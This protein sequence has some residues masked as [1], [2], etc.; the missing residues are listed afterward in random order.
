MSASDLRSQ[1]ETVRA[2]HVCGSGVVSSTMDRGVGLR[3]HECARCGFAYVSPRPT[4]EAM[5]R[6]YEQEYGNEDLDQRWR[7]S[8][9]FD[10]PGADVRRVERLIG[11]RG[12]RGATVLDVGCGPGMLLEALRRRGARQLFGI[13]PGAEAV[14][15]ARGR[16][17]QATI[18]RGTFEDAGGALGQR[19]F[20]LICGCDLIEHLYDPRAFVQ[21]ARERLTP[22]GLLY[23]KTPNWHAVGRYGRSW[24]GLWRD[25]E[26]IFYFSRSTLAALLAQEG[27]ATVAV[28]YE[29]YRAGLGGTS[30]LP[31]LPRGQRVLRL[32]RA[33][34]RPVP[35]VNRLTY[36]TL[37][38][39][40]SWRNRGDRREGTAHALIVAAR[41][42]DTGSATSTRGTAWGPS[43]E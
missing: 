18:I 5:L 4:Q 25:F 26:H 16:L 36:R 9:A 17:P 20:D 10:V 30:R 19:T 27:L 34:V 2:C 40:R 37:E 42:R 8:V 3:V 29:P 31:A 38:G 1:V 33:A 39:L 35:G 15:F 12:V 23:V 32:A 43:T 6:H 14:R 41:P 7:D 21:W 11:S 28:A 24:E 13:E 22:D